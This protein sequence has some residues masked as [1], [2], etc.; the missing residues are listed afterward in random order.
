MKEC[1]RNFSTTL[2]EQGNARLPILIEFVDEIY[3]KKM[4][5]R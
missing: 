1:E 2:P 5:K 3:S 4:F